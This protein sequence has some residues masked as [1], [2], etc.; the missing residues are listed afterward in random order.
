MKIYLENAEE[1]IAAKLALCGE[2]D[3]EKLL[4][5]SLFTKVSIYRAIRNLSSRRVLKKHRYDDGRTFL[6]LSTVGGPGY[7]EQ[8]SPALLKN[9]ESV[10]SS[11]LRYSGSKSSRM[12]ERYNYEFYTHIAD[13]DLQIN[14][15]TTEYRAKEKFSQTGG[16]RSTGRTFLGMNEPYSFEEAA[17]SVEKGYTGLITKKL[18]KKRINGEISREGSIGSRISGT[19]VLNGQVYQAYAL[20][21]PCVSAWKPESEFN[22][23]SYVTGCI[24]RYSPYMSEGGAQIE[25]RCILLFPSPAEAEKMITGSEEKTLR[26]DPCRIYRESYVMPSFIL[27]EAHIRLLGTPF[28]RQSMITTLF[29]EVVISEYGNASMPDDTEIYNFIGCD[30][31][32][33]RRHMPHI[34]YTENK[35]LLLVESWMESAVHKAYSGE[36]V[37]IVG[38]APEDV[39]VIASAITEK[40]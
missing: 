25:A 40:S 12:R 37:E 4:E 22:A 7:I 8:L 23:A 31:N 6:R 35:V 20:G 30:L 32:H 28:W 38:L 34:E 27:S 1:Y 9:A 39:D 29:P 21:D 14:D 17:R 11:D 5:D 24:E 16:V 15:I 19:L 13:K 26:I 18:I 2:L 10:I 3:M 33:M 36:N